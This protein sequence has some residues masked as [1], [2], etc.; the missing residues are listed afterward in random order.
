MGKILAE[1]PGYYHSMKPS[2]LPRVPAND[3]LAYLHGKNPG[4]PERALRAD[5][6][7]VRRQVQGISRV[8]RF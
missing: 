7:R 2:D 1:C 4:F 5:L 6:D 3:W 8:A